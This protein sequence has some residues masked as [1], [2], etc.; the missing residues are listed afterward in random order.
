MA[1][2]PQ[3]AYCPFLY[4]VASVPGSGWLVGQAYVSSSARIYASSPGELEIS[5]ESQQE[6]DSYF[7]TENFAFHGPD[8]F[9]TNYAGLTEYFQSI[10]AAFEDR[11]IR[12]GIIIAEGDLIACQTWIEGTF[13]RPFTHSPAGK[14]EPN[15]A[16]VVWDLMS[17]FRF[18]DRGRL[19]EEFVRTD[20]RSFLRQ[21]G[22]EVA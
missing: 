7:D 3:C 14:L 15:G 12:R 16:R 5:G 13:T 18:D 19:V 17:I 1:R 4:G 22:A 9:D 6:A 21:L 11:T 8:G 10:R 2:D 20:N